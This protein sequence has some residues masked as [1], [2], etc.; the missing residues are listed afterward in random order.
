LPRL[1]DISIALDNDTIADPATSRPSIEYTAHAATGPA[2][3]ASFP[4]MTVD[5]LPEAMGWA[6][7]SIRL[8]THNGTHVDAPWHYHPTMDGGA[9]AMTIDEVPLDWFMQPGVKLDFRH[10]PDGRVVTPDEIDAELTRI[11]HTLMPL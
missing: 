5:R 7:E 9:R 4:G 3:V 2:L 6:I 11:E 10:L 1:I 8:S